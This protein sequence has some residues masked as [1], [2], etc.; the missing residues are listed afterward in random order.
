MRDP[1]P[2]GKGDGMIIKGVEV[3]L[4]VTGAAAEFMDYTCMFAPQTWCDSYE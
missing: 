3:L 1:E 2:V 4:A